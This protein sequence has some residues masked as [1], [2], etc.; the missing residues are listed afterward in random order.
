[1]SL[2]SE[3]LM[4][5]QADRPLPQPR[6]RLAFPAHARHSTSGILCAV[7]NSAFVLLVLLLADSPRLL[8]FAWPALSF[9]EQT[10][11]QTLPPATPQP[12]PPPQVAPP[13]PSGPVIVLDPAHGGTDTGARGENGIA[14]K[15]IVL[16][17]AR[18]VREQL[19]REGYHLLLTR[20]DDSNPSYDERAAL[21]NVYR[22]A[23]FISLHV[24]STGTPGTARAYYDQFSA[25]VLPSTAP[26]PGAKS[27]AVPA[28]SLAIWEEAQR[29]YVDAS[30]RL[31]DSIQNELA[32]SLA[33]SPY[34][35]TAAPVRALRSVTAPAVAIEVSSVSGSTP[36]SLAGAAG[37]LSAAIAH[38]IAGLRQT[39]AAQVR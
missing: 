15:D 36:D 4:H 6:T 37:P 5:T 34:G 9:Q 25:P 28:N 26:A 31:A 14:E 3:N 22:D 18:S 33:G 7:R 23:V 13:P 12:A 35:S 11:P 27:T 29:P 38:G 17:I 1:M 30:H 32:Q 19:A 16:Q 24:S 20:N 39:N 2:R 10:E 21:A 8:L